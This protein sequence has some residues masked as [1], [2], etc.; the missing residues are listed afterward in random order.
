VSKRK[1]PQERPRRVDEI[2][3]AARAY[4]IV[5][6]RC[7]TLG[8][9]SVKLRGRSRAP[10]GYAPDLDSLWRLVCELA[11]ALDAGETPHSRGKAGAGSRD[12]G[13]GRAR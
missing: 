3:A 12:D 7:G 6:R 9:Y 5:I 1:L 8:E 13:A 11:E 10:I 2:A 4:G